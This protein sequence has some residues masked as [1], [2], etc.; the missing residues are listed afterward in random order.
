MHYGQQS[1]RNI[2]S[3]HCTKCNGINISFLGA[4]NNNNNNNNNNL[5]VVGVV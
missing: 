1:L 3:L 4:N 2:T 5:I